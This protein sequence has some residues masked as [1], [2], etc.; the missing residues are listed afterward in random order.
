M[1]R[2]A[3]PGAVCG[4]QGSPLTTVLS[5]KKLEGDAPVIR[6]TSRTVSPDP[7]FETNPNSRFTATGQARGALATLRRRLPRESPRGRRS[8]RPWHPVAGEWSCMRPL[9]RQTPARPRLRGGHARFKL[10]RR[11][12]AARRRVA[13]HD[14]PYLVAAREAFVGTPWTRP[15]LARPTSAGLPPSGWQTL[16]FA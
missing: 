11:A 4:G 5:T 15:W 13:Y 16:P 12:K 8:H 3:Q 9:L 7:G 1:C 6:W 10:G 14:R 2:H